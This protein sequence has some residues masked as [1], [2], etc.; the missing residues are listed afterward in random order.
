MNR[1]QKRLTR[2][3]LAE[4]HSYNE[5]LDKGRNNQPMSYREKQKMIKQIDNLE[6]KDHIGILKIIMESS[7]NKIYTVNNYGTYFDLNDIDNPT[8]WK[9][10]YHVSLCLENVGR[11]KDKKVAEKKYL[12]DR[13][14]F[15]ENLRS[16]AKLKLTANHL[17]LTTT[18]NDSTKKNK[19]KEDDDDDL[20]VENKIGIDIEDSDLPQI[21][22][23]SLDGESICDYISE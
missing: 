14:Q 20:K 5:V 17:T 11:E 18:Q 1:Q 7:D 19:T 2:N 4:Y 3:S 9:I 10:S 21:D 6:T 13:N 16:R 22:Q 12:E 15:E 8:L 23:Y